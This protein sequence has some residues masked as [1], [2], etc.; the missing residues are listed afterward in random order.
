VEHCSFDRPAQPAQRDAGGKVPDDRTVGIMI[1]EGNAYEGD[2]II[3][4]VIRKNRFAHY[5]YGV[6]VGSNDANK[7]QYGH[8]IAYNKID[9]CGTEG[10]MVKCGDTQVRGNTVINCRNNSISVI[11]GEG[12]IVEDNRILDCG[13]GIRIAGRGHTVSNNCIVRCG[14]EAIKIMGRDGKGG[15][16]TENVI[17]EKNTCIAWSQNQPQGQYSGI[18]IGSETNA[19]VQRNLFLGPGKP[20]EV[21]GCENS[22]S[23][24]GKARH[25]ILDNYS[26]AHSCKPEN[27]MSC[28]QVIFSGIARD[29]YEN[30]T[31]YGAQGWMARPEPF[32]PDEC[33]QGTN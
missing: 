18:S 20:Y 31:G 21:I 19:I 15:P 6:L 12:S 14:E 13:T 17:I 16:K 22:A 11:A 9:N 8:L 26:A 2:P 27:G 1:S 4:H 29:N 7:E 32:D 33:G 25:C 23:G 10:I 28:G 5:N 30:G 3:D 24:P